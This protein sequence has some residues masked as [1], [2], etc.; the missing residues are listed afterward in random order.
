VFL[1]QNLTID[2]NLHKATDSKTHSLS[3]EFFIPLFDL[4]QPTFALP[5]TTSREL[6]VYSSSFD[7]RLMQFECLLERITM[8]EFKESATFRFGSKFS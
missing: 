4:A 5:A 8:A 2:Q 6:H 7:L 3:I 1:L